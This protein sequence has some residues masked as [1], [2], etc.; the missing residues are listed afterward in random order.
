MEE[1][2]HEM[3]WK[4]FVR[5]P[6][7]HI[8][9]SA[10]LDGNAVIPTAE[11]CREYIPSILA[12]TTPIADGAMFGGL[13]LYAL[14]KKYNDK[15]DEELKKEIHILINGLFMLCDVSKVDGFI[16]RGVADDGVTH[17]PCSSNDQTGPWILGLWKAMHSDVT[18]VAMKEE[19]KKRLYRTLNGF[20]KN[21]WYFRNE[22]E[23][24]ALGTLKSGDWRDSAKFLFAAAVA[25]ELG[26]VSDE[27][28][29]SYADGIPEKGFYSRR[30][31][32]SKGFV[33]EMLAD[34]V[35]KQFWIT[36]C[37]HLSVCE[38]L[39]LDTK[40]QEQY[41][42]AISLNVYTSKFFVREF[43]NYVPD[44]FP[45]YDH[46]WRKIVPQLKKGTTYEEILQEGFRANPLYNKQICPLRSHER[47][48]LGQALFS[49]W[50]AI[51]G[52]DRAV[53][54][55]ALSCLEECIEKTDWNKVGQSLAFAAESALIAYKVRWSDKS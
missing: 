39:N 10:D 31:L 20:Y 46:D 55:Y 41:K 32:I 2:L 52:E 1:R 17:Y 13:Y 44:T 3:V 49:A 47:K 51:E 37:A 33:H 7:G 19:I 50:I 53:A 29:E 27:E 9:D 5:M 11:E 18:D 8:M 42:Q 12:Y 15:P 25:K 14:C 22:W 45:P 16:A 21:D 35:L 38:L 28:F 24:T 34:S 54:E 40:G 48:T 36:V 23:G 4:R 43:D 6:Y 30:E 26:I